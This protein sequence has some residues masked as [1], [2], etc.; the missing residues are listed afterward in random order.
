V[1]SQSIKT[2]RIKRRFIFQKKK[3]FTKEQA[4]DWAEKFGIDWKDSMMNSS[5]GMDVELE[6]GSRDPLPML[7]ATLMTAK[8]RPCALKRIPGLLH[9]AGG[10][11]TKKQ[12]YIGTSE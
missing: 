6:H 8:N 4:L 10:H 1:V 7:P 5:M 9:H 11:V 3:Y 12:R 2:G